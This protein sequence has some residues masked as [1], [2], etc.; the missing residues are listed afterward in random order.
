[1]TATETAPA[2][3]QSRWGYHPCSRETF[4]LLKRLHKHYWRAVRAHAAWKRWE[5]KSPHNR[6]IREAKT[7]RVLGPRPEPKLCPVF[8][9]RETVRTN[10]VGGKY[11][12][13]GIDVVRVSTGDHGVIAAFHNARTPKATPGEVVP[14]QLT[15]AEI[16]AMV[17]QLDR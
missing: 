5:R 4:R 1:M 17:A 15:E 16:R 13:E 2:V 11:H 7:G 12:R 9:A 10:W 14:L 6:V 8:T 3:H